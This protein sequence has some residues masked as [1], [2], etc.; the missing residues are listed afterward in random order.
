[1]SEKEILGELVVNDME[2]LRRVVS[3]SKPYIAIEE[4]SGRTI[5]Q[6]PK[7][8][9]GQKELASLFLAGRFF[10][11]KLG[12]TESD[13]M[14]LEE[15]SRETGVDAIALSKRLSELASDGYVERSG[16]GEFRI[17]YS[18][19]GQLLDNLSGSAYVLANQ[20]TDLSPEELPDIGNPAGLND[21]IIKSL[22]SVWGRKRPRTW[23]EIDEAMKSNAQHFSQGS[24]TGALTYLV[25]SNRLRR[26]KEGGIYGYTLPTGEG[27]N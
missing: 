4:K 25:R 18:L 2:I 8:Q 7:S 11:F 16:R 10:A 9:L 19:L 14:S 17:V 27:G 21:A 1:M 20:E 15:L 13:T 3:K 6:V 12:K 24:I 23:H 26:V 22:S 5:L